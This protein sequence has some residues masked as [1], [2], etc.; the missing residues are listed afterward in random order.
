MQNKPNSKNT[1]TNP[2]PCPK[3]IYED[4]PL[5][6]NEK[7]KPNSNPIL[8]TPSAPRCTL[9]NNQSKS[10][11]PK[12]AQTSVSAHKLG[13]KTSK[14]HNPFMQNKP[15]PKNPKP[16][17]TPLL[18]MTY[19]NNPPRPTRKNKP[20][21]NP[22]RPN[23][24]AQIDKTNPIQTQPNPIPS[25]SKVPTFPNSPHPKLNPSAVHLLALPIIPFPHRP[26]KSS[27]KTATHKISP[28]RNS[29]PPENKIPALFPRTRPL[30]PVPTTPLRLYCTIAAGNIQNPARS[31]CVSARPGE[32][33]QR[34][35]RPKPM[36]GQNKT[37][38]IEG[39]Q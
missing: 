13:A 36:I 25:S 8:N 31:A 15:N 17:P 38:L 2:T 20:N 5:P 28:K 4:Y 12:S 1:K 34:W 19:N 29:Q 11:S 22:I 3:K 6:G 14:N 35:I 16:N 7:N 18:T 23:P 37:Y 30:Q 26:L 39:A 21:S 32:K 10:L 27:P 33:S 24:T 9:P